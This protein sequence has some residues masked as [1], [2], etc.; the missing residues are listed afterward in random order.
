MTTRNELLLAAKE[1]F[2][3]AYLAAFDQFLP[4]TIEEA[5]KEADN[6]RS[7][8]EQS[9]Y[10]AVRGVLRDRNIELRANLHR[11]M[12]KLLRRS[13]Q[14]AYSAF[15]P[16][17]ALSG[18]DG[19]LSLVEPS[20]FEGEL[21]LVA[22]TDRFRNEAEDQ[23]RDLN[24]RIALLFGQAEVKEREVPFRP[25]LVSR[26]LADASEAMGLSRELTGV[27]T[28]L[29]AAS[30]ENA[31]DGIYASVNSFLAQNGIAADLPLR[32]KKS[33]DKKILTDHFY[34]KNSETGEIT[35]KDAMAAPTHLVSGFRLAGGNANSSDSPAPSRQ[36][37]EQFLQMIKV[38]TESVSTQKNVQPA[39]NL[40]AGMI[41]HFGSDARRSAQSNQVAGNGKDISAGLHEQRVDQLLE[42][43]KFYSKITP[44]VADGMAHQAGTAGLLAQQ[45][46]PLQPQQA[47]VAMN[48]V[49]ALSL[50]VVKSGW[51]SVPQ[52]AGE[53]LRKLMGRGTQGV[54]QGNDAAYKPPA[55]AHK[56]TVALA[57]V[58]DTL[59]QKEALAAVDKPVGHGEARNRILEQRSYLA[60]QTQ[61]IDEQMTIDVVA[62]LFE[63]VL[64]DGK[65]SAEVRVQ[66]GRLQFLVLKLALRDPALLSQKRHPARVLINGISS[67]SAG[68]KHIDPGG[69]RVNA[70]IRLI[71]ETLLNAAVKDLDQCTGLFSSLLGEFS[72]FVATELRD[73]DEKLNR[74]VQAIENAQSRTLRFA[75][76]SAQMT[77]I[78]SGVILDDFLHAFLSRTWVEV[79]DRAEDLDA[80]RAE[81]F[82][83]L[84][85]DLIWSIAPKVDE[86]DRQQ[87]SA[88]LPVMINTLR[89][90]MLLIG[91]P[92]TQ[93]KEML[94]WLFDAHTR[95]VRSINVSFQIPSLDLMHN[96]FER[97]IKDVPVES[98]PATDSARQ[99]AEKVL[100]DAAIR[101]LDT[102][103]Q[104][105]DNYFDREAAAGQIDT[106]ASGPVA[107]IPEADIQF[108]ADIRDRLHSGIFIEIKLDKIASRAQLSWISADA[109]NLILKLDGQHTPLLMSLRVFRRL[110]VNQRVRFMEDQP[111][112][113]RAVQSLLNLAEYLDQPPIAK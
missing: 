99:I 80:A 38:M 90:G 94:G 25:Y 110:V 95:A 68:L 86:F 11:G 97:L 88:I 4:Y 82:R 37:V 54:A 71:V 31:I 108:D 41:N 47:Q 96:T 65:V 64:R 59:L 23:L 60:V 61:V 32:I 109:A 17:F 107:A 39:T 55:P 20:A 112:F 46:G 7:S 36:S 106:G 35:G 10:L 1:E 48:P 40:E 76:I 57:Q 92:Q 78:L 70:K 16:A 67:I 19:A 81:R 100:M 98:S 27:L 49:S 111:L 103:I 8:L 5:I 101:Q 105:F 87:L 102:D 28:K 29:L 91:W 34:R 104:S 13:L 66:L 24:I 84:V 30:V 18:H 79:I 83:A 12:E 33:P 63:F 44:A 72:E 74:A 42:M 43:V 58:I 93:Q 75:H 53:V 50:R 22:F 21:R 26:S 6:S 3:R 85:P 77:E 56:I 89:E 2:L 14:T 73:Q 15:R 9:H 45:T 69:V 52:T 51:L 113:E 62:M